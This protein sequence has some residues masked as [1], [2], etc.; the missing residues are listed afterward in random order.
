MCSSDLISCG[1]YLFLIPNYYP[2]IVKYDTA[3]DTV[4]YIQGNQDVFAGTAP[5]GERYLGGYCVCD[6]KLYLASP[7][8][9][10]ILVVYAH[11]G[12]QKIAA[13]EADGVKGFC[14]LVCDGTDIWC[15]PYEGKTI[16]RWNPKTGEQQG[17]ADLLQGLTCKHPVRKY[18]CMTIPFS[19]AV[20]YQNEVFLSP[21]WGNMFVRLDKDSGKMTEWKPPFPVPEKEKNGYFTFS[22]MASFVTPAKNVSGREHLV[23]SGYD[24]KLYKIDLKTNEWQEI[25][26]GFDRTDLEK[27][28]A[29]FQK[30][31][32]WLQYCCLENAF[33]SLPD[34]LD[35]NITGHAFDR[36]SHLDA[37]GSIAAN[38]D[39]TSGE[40]IYEFVKEKLGRK[41]T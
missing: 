26:I 33:N 14:G 18:E 13:L 1:D 15:L 12:E 21:G 29:G 24:R 19:R 36:Q 22:G 40:K 32:Q 27:G 4:Q 39:G 7:L 5:N 11:T 31:S 25:D 8:D 16:V 17:Y 10:R 28:E 23:F 38:H 41:P 20:F 6:G 34:F 37:Y 3:K 30:E 35:G 2:A 9:N